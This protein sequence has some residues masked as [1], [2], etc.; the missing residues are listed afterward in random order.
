MT[1]FV[2]VCNETLTECSM[3]AVETL[4]SPLLPP[5]SLTDVYT[6]GSSISALWAL[7][8]VFNKAGKVT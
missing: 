6:L 2:Q 7:A 5:L 4:T 8:W 3:V 1:G